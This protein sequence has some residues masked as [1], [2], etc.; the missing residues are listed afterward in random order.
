[1]LNG[2]DGQTPHSFHQPRKNV[3]FGG[4][5]RCPDTRL[6]SGKDWNPKMAGGGT[7]YQN[8][9]SG[10]FDSEGNRIGGIMA[11]KRSVWTVTTQP[12]KDAHFATYPPDLIKPCIL[13]GSKA[14]D[15]ILDPFTGSGTTGMVALELGRKAVLIELNAEYVKLIARRCDVTPGLALA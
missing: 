3:K 2:A 7:S 5:N 15:T 13:A 1:M 12:F 4:N 8:G 11:N 9:H 14:G 10:Y 6:Q